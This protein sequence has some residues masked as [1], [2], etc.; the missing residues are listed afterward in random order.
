[1]S[2]TAIVPTSSP[3]QRPIALLDPWVWRMA[4][5]D[6]RRSRGRLLVF[7]TA[8]TLG[9]AA[10][11]AIGS[12][13]WNLQRAIHEQARTLVGADLVVEAPTP[14]D[15]DAENSSPRSAAPSAARTKPAGLHVHVSENR[16]LAADPGP[17]HRRALTRS[18]ADRDRPAAGRRALSPR[19][20]A[21]W[22]KAASCCN[23]ARTRR[24]DPDR[25]R[26][27]AH[28]RR[29]HEAARRGQR[30]RQ[31]RPARAHPARPA[32]RVAAR[33]RQPRALP[34]LPEAARRDGRAKAASPRTRRSSTN[35]TWRPTP[36]P[37]ARASSD[38]CSPT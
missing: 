28:P 33:A 25:R 22:W 16:R 32:A 27:A 35:G 2:A 5:R 21:R 26:D 11:V 9:V 30:V 37:T 17:R 24:P 31:H 7:S 15:A 6:S 18:T 13:G 29:G 38:G 8:L 20:R 14:L 36:S 19:A 4:W 12:L 3:T 23:T 1:M 34:D 10:L